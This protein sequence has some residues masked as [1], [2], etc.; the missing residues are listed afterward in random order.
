MQNGA[1]VLSASISDLFHKSIPAV[2]LN[3][4][5]SLDSS[6]FNVLDPNPSL[7]LMDRFQ[8]NLPPPEIDKQAAGSAMADN[9]DYATPLINEWS[10]LELDR[11]PPQPEYL[12][13]D[14]AC[15]SISDLFHKSIPAVQLNSASSLDSPYFN[16]LDPNLSL[17]L[18]DRFQSNLPPPE[19]DKQAAG[20]AMADNMDY[21]TPLV[22]EWSGLELDGFPP[23]PEYLPFD[24]AWYDG[25]MDGQ[26]AASLDPLDGFSL[27]MFF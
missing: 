12:P 23:Q 25:W 20:W 15:A 4:A 6:Y 9:M 18:M 24:P 13:L 16:V 14:P 22:D 8:S 21:A 26:E 17:G 27:Y 10:G 3:S 5:S 2:Q 1:F 7:G 11:F 19:I